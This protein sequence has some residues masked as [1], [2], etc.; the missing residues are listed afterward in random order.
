MSGIICCS[1]KHP[2]I[3]SLCSCDHEHHSWETNCSSCGLQQLNRNKPTANQ[4]I[5]TELYKIVPDIHTG[6]EEYR[7]YIISLK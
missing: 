5:F 4:N 1:R 2:T 6:I 7:Y 3:S